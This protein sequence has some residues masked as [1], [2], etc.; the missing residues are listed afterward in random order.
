[1]YINY[2]IITYIYIY[3]IILIYLEDIWRQLK[4]ADIVNTWSWCHHS[5]AWRKGL[6][7]ARK[8]SRVNRKRPFVPDAMVR[9]SWKA[10][11]ATRFRILVEMLG[12][13]G[14]LR[15]D[16]IF[17]TNFVVIV[18]LCMSLILQAHHEKRFYKSRSWKKE[19][20]TSNIFKHFLA[21]KT[22]SCLKWSLLI[23][24]LLIQKN[25]HAGKSSV[26]FFSISKTWI[27]QCLT[28]KWTCWLSIST[29][30]KLM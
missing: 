14:G 7:F 16:D 22:G 26:A 15:W 12:S 13:Q 2:L 30:W 29:I 28:N 27:L 24:R 3:D 18:A 25:R 17:P 6:T 5:I 1:M 11:T 9:F 19:V 21:S 10:G 23:G 4:H 8:P 20:G